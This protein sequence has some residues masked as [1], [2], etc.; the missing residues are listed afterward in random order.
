MRG[1]V[2][3]TSNT[4][5]IPT[6]SNLYTCSVTISTSATIGQT[7]PLTC[8]GDGVAPNASDPTGIPLSTV[9]TN[10]AILV[11][12]L[13]TDTPT[14]TPT[15][16]PVIGT[17]TDTPTGTATATFTKVPT[18]TRG[19]GGGGNDDDSCAIASPANSTGGWMLLL[20]A[21][22]LLWIRRRSR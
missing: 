16:T 15:F 14:V 2:L 6:G 13:P 11:G 10:G 18:N 20:P 7:F 8:S 22:A 17:P 9:C 3:S 5:E 21:A 1:I 19:P 4:T 12:S